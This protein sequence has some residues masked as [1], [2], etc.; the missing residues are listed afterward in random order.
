MRKVGID[1]LSYYV[2]SLY[3]DIED[4]AIKREIVPDKLI[5]GIGSQ[6]NGYSRL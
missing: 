1:S 5:K 3:V 2:P 6:K 4:L